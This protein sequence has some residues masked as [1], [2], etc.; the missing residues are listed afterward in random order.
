MALTGRPQHSGHSI[1]IRARLERR[2]ARHESQGCFYM[3]EVCGKMQ[4]RECVLIERVEGCAS[5][6][7]CR[8]LRG[9]ILFNG[10]VQRS[11]GDERN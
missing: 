6:N 8:D 1:V 7:H 10:I 3:T 5:L 11:C 9:V 2:T 4:S